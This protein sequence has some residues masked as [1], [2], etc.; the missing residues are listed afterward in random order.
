VNKRLHVAKGSQD[1]DLIILV[2]WLLLSC[3]CDL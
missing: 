3:F 2:S 1:L